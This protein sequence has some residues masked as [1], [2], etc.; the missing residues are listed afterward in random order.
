M[1]NAKPYLL[2]LTSHSSKTGEL[3]EDT[4]SAYLKEKMSKDVE[5]VQIADLAQALS[6][7]RDM[8]PYRSFVV[9]STVYDAAENLPNSRSSA[10]WSAA[11]KSKKPRL[12][13]K[14]VT[15][16]SHGVLDKEPIP[17]L[18]EIQL[19]SATSYKETCRSPVLLLRL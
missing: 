11:N 7:R 15:M 6:V 16:S 19:A 5:S 10:P 9:A 13:L 17:H 3:L 12:G 4:L 18:C 1:V 2:P 8:H 14:L